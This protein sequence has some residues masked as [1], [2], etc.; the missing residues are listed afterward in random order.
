MKFT[1]LSTSPTIFCLYQKYNKFR[2]FIL[3]FWMLLACSS[4]DLSFFSVQSDHPM[5]VGIHFHW[6]SFD[7]LLLPCPFHCFSMSEVVLGTTQLNPRIHKN[8][9]HRFIAVLQCRNKWLLASASFSHIL[10]LEQIYIPLMG[11]T[12][13][14]KHAFLITN[15]VKHDTFWETLIFQ[16]SFHGQSIPIV[17]LEFMF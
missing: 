15:H 4:W 16:I 13:W 1:R 5:H 14:V 8:M 7:L 3:I 9:S 11:N 10:H 6:C 17:W 12:S 2:F